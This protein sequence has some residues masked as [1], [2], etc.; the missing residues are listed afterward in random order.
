MERL[1][2]ERGERTWRLFHI[3]WYINI[4][5][6]AAAG[7]GALFFL[8]QVMSGASAAEP[9]NIITDIT[10]MIG[11]AIIAIVLLMGAGLSRY[12]ARLEGQHLELKMA[13]N[14]LAS[15]LSA[16][17]REERGQGS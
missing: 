10:L 17:R 3:G 5:C 11:L 8:K 12:Q 2:E 15:G 14:K 13:I 7:L 9:T 4:A 6:V 16:S 1:T